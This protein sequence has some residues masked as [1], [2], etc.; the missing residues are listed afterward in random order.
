MDK[1]PIEAP[2]STC[3]RC[4]SLPPKFTMIWKGMEEGRRG[5]VSLFQSK[6]KISVLG[7][8]SVEIGEIPLGV[9]ESNVTRRT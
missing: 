7:G 8:G 6:E 1:I 4:I 5:S 9:E 3:V 2:S